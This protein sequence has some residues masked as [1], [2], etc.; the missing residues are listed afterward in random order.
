VAMLCLMLASDTMSAV[1]DD[2]EDT[3]VMSSSC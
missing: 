2:K 1:C 3:I